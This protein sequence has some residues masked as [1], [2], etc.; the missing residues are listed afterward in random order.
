MFTLV[1]VA[2][3]LFGDRLTTLHY[4][5]RDWHG[6]LAGG[7]SGLG[8]ALANTGAPPFTAYLLLQNVSPLA[9]A[10]TATLFFAFVNLLK[11]PGLILA[12]LLDLH[13]LIAIAWAIPLIPLGVWAG[14]WMIHRIDRLA[15]E[16]LM[17]VVLVIASMVLIFVTPK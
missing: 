8:A 12:G 11:L 7:V 16:R 3:K 14:R 17:L 10:A 6:Y 4:Q 5:P 2:Y 13:D 15:F 9:F 1:F